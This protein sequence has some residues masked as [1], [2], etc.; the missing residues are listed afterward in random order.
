MKINGRDI[1][2]LELAE[3]IVKGVIA[4]IPYAGGLASIYGDWQN[5]VQF[6]NVL[7]ILTKH[8]QLLLEFKEFINN[9]YV[10]SD[11]YTYDTIQTVL[12]GQN[13]LDDNKR[14]LYAKYLTSCCLSQNVDEEYHGTILDIISRMNN[15][16]FIILKYIDKYAP[17]FKP[18]GSIDMTR[19]Y[20][21]HEVGSEYN[22]YEIETRIDYLVSLSL[23]RRI[24]IENIGK[25]LSSIG[26]EKDVPHFVGTQ[27]VFYRSNLGN[28]IVDFMSKLENT[29]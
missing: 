24:D 16:D 7:D 9:M 26:F 19:I 6:T 18:S 29:L 15:I 22:N 14:T 13:E 3:S 21:N 11:R 12:K 5:K 4:T 25:A 27:D 1:S 17:H 10:E 2:A 20:V 8:E 23:A 28:Q